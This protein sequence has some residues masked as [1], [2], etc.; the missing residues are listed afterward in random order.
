[1]F[2]FIICCKAFVQQDKKAIFIWGLFI[3]NSEPLNPTS[4]PMRQASI[5]PKKGKAKAK[6]Q[7]KKGLVFSDF[8]L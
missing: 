8:K 1:M 3:P 5:V 4:L 6:E 2:S 7:K